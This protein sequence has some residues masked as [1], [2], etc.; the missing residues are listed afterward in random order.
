[1]TKFKSAASASKIIGIIFTVFGLIFSIIGIF[2]IVEFNNFAA[3]AES[4]TAEITRIETY[5]TRGRKGKIKTHHNV[6]IEYSVDGV[7]YNTQL[8]YYSSFMREG[9]TIE[10]YYDPEKP[11]KARGNDFSV[12]IIFV[13][14][15][16][17]FALVGVLVGAIPAVKLRRK[18][19]LI[20]TG[21]QATGVITNVV[22]DRTVKINGRHP[23]KAECEVR[24]EFTGELYLYSSEGV[25]GNI[26]HLI[27]QSV[28][29]YYDANDRSKYYVDLD[30]VTE[31]FIESDT[32]VHDFR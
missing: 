21:A 17:F 8:D 16:L 18:K 10:V 32:E 13:A 30:S 5:T 7:T 27:G 28:A 12:S 3:S 15:G 25:M 29:V 31:N 1:M 24:D 4:T 9:G 26:N 2:T 23:N 19:K 11:G 6:F 22:P 20:E 14:I